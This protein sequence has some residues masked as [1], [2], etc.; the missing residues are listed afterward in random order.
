[1]NNN[2][3]ELKEL[4]A[5]SDEVTERL[6]KYLIKLQKEVA[7]GWEE[8]AVLLKEV[9]ALDDVL[10]YFEEEA[11]KGDQVSLKYYS[12]LKYGKLPES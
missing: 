4:I 5:L 7:E 12:R 10:A 8:V 11:D 3:K 9:G 6:S 1:M 2:D